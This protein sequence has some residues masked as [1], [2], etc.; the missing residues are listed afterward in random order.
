M[1]VFWLEAIERVFT[2]KD[3]LLGKYRILNG[4]SD[5]YIG[6]VRIIRLL[7]PMAVFAFIAL[8][9]VLLIAIF[10]TNSLAKFASYFFVHEGSY[11]E[12][13]ADFQPICGRKNTKDDPKVVFFLC[14]SLSPCNDFQ[15][16]AILCP[17]LIHYQTWR[18]G[19]DSNSWCRLP[20]TSV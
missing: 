15:L 3:S 9:P 13:S 1:K 4:N 17:N 8:F 18:R 2:S 6:L 10:D 5:W 14:F 11:L 7:F 20:S 19:R 16:V 12:P